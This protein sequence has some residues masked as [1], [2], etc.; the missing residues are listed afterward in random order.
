LAGS[1]RLNDGGPAIRTSFRNPQGIALD[2][3]GNLYIADYF[4]NRVR[5]VSASGTVSTIAGNGVADSYGDG[6]P[7]TDAAI[8]GPTSVAIDASGNILISEYGTCLIRKV[9]TDN[10]ISTL[11]GKPCFTSSPAFKGEGGPASA[12]TFSPDAIALDS[13]GNI[14]VADNYNYRIYKISSTGILT[15][16]VGNGSHGFSGDG[17]PG[18]SARIGYVGGIAVDASGKP[19]FTDVEHFRIRVL[20]TS[21]IVQTVVGNGSSTSGLF[22]GIATQVNVEPLALTIDTQSEVYFSDFLNGLVLKYDAVSQSVVPVAGSASTG[23]AGD[24]GPALAAKLNYPEGL[25][26]D[27]TGVLYIADTFNGRIRKVSAGVI[28]TV[29]GAGQKDGVVA[30]SA[31][32][33]RPSGVTSDAQG[34]VYIA[35][36]LSYEIRKVAGTSD[37]LISRIGDFSLN[38]G[39]PVSVALDAAGNIYATTTNN[40]LTK[41]TPAGVTSIVAGDGYPG[42]SGDGG[43]ATAAEFLNPTA[44]AFDSKGDIYVAD[45][46]NAVVRKIT[47]DGNISTVAGVAD[48]F[49]YGGDGG[50]ATQAG[51]DPFA[52][53][54]DANDNLLIADLINSAIR[55]VDHAT[56]IISTIAGA[57]DYDAAGARGLAINASIGWPNGIAAAAD[58]SIY[59]SD[60]W[61]NVVWRISPTGYASIIAGSGVSSPANGE[62]GSALAANMRPVAVSIAKS[63]NLLVADYDND[64]VRLLTPIAI[65][66][67]SFTY[68]SGDGQYAAPGSALAQPLQAYLDGSDGSPYFGYPVSFTVTSGDATITPSSISTDANGIASATVTL[69]PTL[70]PVTVQASVPGFSPVSFKLQSVTLPVVPTTGIVGAGGSNPAVTTISPNGIFSIY[71][72]ALAAETRKL[73]EADIVNGMLPTNLGG[74]CV[75]VGGVRAP[76]FYVS[77]LQINAQVPAVTPGSNV[78]V[79]VI[80]NCETSGEIKGAPVKVAVQAAAPEFFA[81]GYLGD[82]SGAVAATDST[83]L[84]LLIGPPGLLSGVTITPAKAGQYVTLYATGL[85]ALQ[86]PLPAG[87]TAPAGTNWVAGSTTIKLAGSDLDPANVLFVGAAPGFAG[88]YQ[89]NIHIPEGTPT[90]HQPVVVTVAGAPSPAN[91]FLE[92]GN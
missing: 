92:I 19:Y 58:G 46:G 61:N 20:N 14:F 68:K 18:T 70:G 30:T 53:A 37:H 71:G 1:D 62:E 77:P 78:S 81:I 8:Y 11:A 2:S 72:T 36:W 89:I 23:F 60:E 39:G 69:G 31:F 21:G 48:D 84:A 67:Q 29:A 42:Y 40:Y 73:L 90:G 16:V 44:V 6:G 3:A 35:D 82:G 9:G 76:L 4:D 7:A 5:K 26:V 57:G 86:S 88:L 38:T 85:G 49:I 13:T 12:A 24:G 59:F 74:T 32:L 64:R 47:P 51:M 34:N 54:L 22:S 50:P 80:L 45:Y 17:A 66:L 55:K 63:G 91:A 43:P 75:E 28:N 65:T 41:T 87:Q 10:K 15:T 33:N 56:G 83:N 52:I 25:A 79:A 27:K